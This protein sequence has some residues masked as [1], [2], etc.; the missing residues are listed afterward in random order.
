MVVLAPTTRR[1]FTGKDFEELYPKLWS[2]VLG[3]EAGADVDKLVTEETVIPDG[4]RVFVYGE[5][6]SAAAPG[7]DETFARR[8]RFRIRG[9]PDRPLVLA[10]GDRKAALRVLRAPVLALVWV[11]F[12]CFVVG[13]LAVAIP[14]FLEARA[15]L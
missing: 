4:A 2:E 3:I 8:R 14:L 10:C 1:V 6:V 15:G 13:A 5:A 7:E 11:A 12:L 9:T